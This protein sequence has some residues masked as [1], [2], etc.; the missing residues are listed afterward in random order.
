MSGSDESEM[1][2]VEFSIDVLGVKNI[3]VC[4]HSECGAMKAIIGRSPSII[5]LTILAICV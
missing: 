3:I 5:T 2:A 1:A 4:G